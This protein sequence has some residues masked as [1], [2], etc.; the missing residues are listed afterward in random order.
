MWKNR[1]L[2]DFHQYSNFVKKLPNIRVSPWLKILWLGPLTNKSYLVTETGRR[3]RSSLSSISSVSSYSPI[4]FFSLTIFN[5]SRLN[6]LHFS[7][8]NNGPEST[9][10][11]KIAIMVTINYKIPKIWR[12]ISV[13]ADRP[14]SGNY[15]G[16]KAM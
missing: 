11:K 16:A 13:S 9:N 12:T 7:L 4:T 15:R 3:V 8:S 1:K 5:C 2:N 14:I 10:Q 6:S